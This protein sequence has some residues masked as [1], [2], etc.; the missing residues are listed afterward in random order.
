[1][2][3]LNR[4]LLD[5][6]KGDDSISKEN[7]AV[8]VEELKAASEEIDVDDVFTQRTADVLRA[9]G[10]ETKFNIKKEKKVS[11]KTNA[12]VKTKT[13]GKKVGKRVP[14]SKQKKEVAKKAPAKSSDT[15]NK[16][17][18][19]GSGSDIVHKAIISSGSKGITK[20]R[21]IRKVDG[22]FNTTNLEGKVTIVL[23]IT[24]NRGLVKVNDRGVYTAE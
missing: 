8:M 16:G 9:L 24:L 14:V 4:E 13:V 11:A 10:V 17:F 18:R 20:E 1:M 3:E 15:N 7:G 12:K 22:K 19:E 23:G 21:L 5:N 6:A 2:G